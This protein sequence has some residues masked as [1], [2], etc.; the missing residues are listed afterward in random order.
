MPDNGPQPGL[1]DFPEALRLLWEG[2]WKAA[3]WGIDRADL[4]SLCDIIVRLADHRLM[5]IEAKGS[6]PGSEHIADLVRHYHKLAADLH[7]WA[8]TP[9]PEPDWGKVAE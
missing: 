8:V 7:R 9:P 2:T 4:V 5:F 1:A 6:P 3:E